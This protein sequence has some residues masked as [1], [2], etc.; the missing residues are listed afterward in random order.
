MS[1]I[2]ST[3]L[4]YFAPLA[5]IYLFYV[6]N[7]L[8]RHKK[9]LKILRSSQEAGLTEASS[10]YP[11]INHNRCI[12]C[13]SCVAACPEQDG[14]AVLGI[15]NGK[16][17]LVGPSYCIG[18]GLCEVVC[19][20]EAITLVYGTKN[21]GVDIPKTDANQETNVPG[22]FI[23]GELGGMGLIH[24]GLLKGRQAVEHIAGQEDIGKGDMLD[25]VIVGS[26]PA[27]F[28]GSL[29]AL[30]KKLRFVTLEQEDAIGGAVYHFPKGK[31]VMTRPVDLS[32]VGKT[33]FKETTKE[34]LLKYW[35]EI[36][37]KTGLSINFKEHVTKIIKADKYFTIE[38]SKETYTSRYVLLALGR[39]GTPRKLGVNG[40]DHCKV[41][42]RLIDPGEHRDKNVLVV[43][44]G[45]SALEAAAC[46]AATPNTQVVLSYRSAAFGRAKEKN[47]RHIE[48][49]ENQGNLKVLLKSNV[50]EI[51]PSH[52]A[53]DQEGQLFKF[54]ND[55]VIVCAG[56]ILPTGF[57]KKTGITV[58]TKYGTP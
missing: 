47:R 22:L 4:F 29:T 6:G 11:V 2:N 15:I 41:A 52:V 13:G 54:E 35:N 45:D 30:E 31:I 5:T 39:R 49:M 19:P 23:A 10:L 53:I 37:T 8:R 42:Y 14:H 17:N 25:L 56:G 36:R 33:P 1:F 58:E 40:E 26:G 48:E 44:G 46:I 9:N 24:T 16:S 51:S 50:K 38:T 32:L 3:I 27:G 57:L 28:S 20:R 21:R 12:G 55:A 7:K 43:G 34:I 18:H